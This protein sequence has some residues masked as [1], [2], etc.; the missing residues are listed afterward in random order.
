M[1]RTA[2]SKFNN[3]PSSSFSS[4]QISSSSESPKVAV[5]SVVATLSPEKTTCSEPEPSLGGEIEIGNDK[6]F[7]EENNLKSSE[8]Q[9]TSLT[10]EAESAP[11]VNEELA[12]FKIGQKLRVQYG[13]GPQIKIYM[14]KVMKIEP[15]NRY[16]VHYLGWNNRYD[17]IID[18]TRVVEVLPEESS[19][20]GGVESPT[21]PPQTKPKG[22]R[23]GGGGHKPVSTGRLPMTESKSA[24]F[25][26]RKRRS[27]GGSTHS[28]PIE[29][30]SLK[31][32]KKR[33]VNLC[34]VKKELTEEIESILNNNSEKWKS[35]SSCNN[36]GGRRSANCTPIPPQMASE[37]V[38]VKVPP[39]KERKRKSA[40][41][42]STDKKVGGGEE[43]DDSNDSEETTVA[44]VRRVSKRLRGEKPIEVAKKLNVT[45]IV[46]K[47][48]E[49]LIKDCVKNE[50]T[51][52]VVEEEN[53]NTV[54]TNNKPSP[55]ASPP[56]ATMLTAEPSSSEVVLK[57]KEPQVTV[58][59]TSVQN[60]PEQPDEENEVKNNDCPAEEKTEK[61]TKVIE[62]VVIEQESKEKIVVPAK[63]APPNPMKRNKPKRRRRNYSHMVTDHRKSTKST[64]K[65]D[66]IGIFFFF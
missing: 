40:T 65:K 59:S 26:S 56:F 13:S 52:E 53:E 61:P 31:K 50:I 20:V 32:Y 47:E 11:A 43:D 51:E 27:S 2:A 8:Q 62:N 30:S 39:V 19:D 22:V 17:E 7:S 57:L 4:K 35:N 54:K 6:S 41:V 48:E 12:E 5:T 55:V 38:F 45:Q 42:S 18:A 29:T 33:E 46:E 60:G 37:E 58:G 44:A 1:K 3:S 64:P 66:G 63:R 24:L 9:Q 23:G 21:V 49:I 28:L 25:S 15:A 34:Q 10:D 36:N 14:A 16:L